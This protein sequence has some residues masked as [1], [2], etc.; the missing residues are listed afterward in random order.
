VTHTARRFSRGDLADLVREAGLDVAR[1]TGA[2]T[3]LVP[4]AAVLAVLERDRAAS[5]VGRNQAGLGGVLPALAR[6]ERAWLRRADLP[7]GLSVIAIGVKP[8]AVIRTDL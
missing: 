7:T 3:F 2:Y 5:D 4:P 6:V 1:A 8:E